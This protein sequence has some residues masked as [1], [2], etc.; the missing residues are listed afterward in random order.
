LKKILNTKILIAS[1]LKNSEK[2]TESRIRIFLRLNSNP[3]G[4]FKVQWVAAISWN[5]LFLGSWSFPQP[6][7]MP[8]ER[9]T[10]QGRAILP[11][12]RIFSSLNKKGLYKIIVKFY[13]N[14]KNIEIP[15]QNYITNAKLWKGINFF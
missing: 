11:A 4:Y 9:N 2:F 12:S 13:Q 5:W 14:V 8:W 6:P 15:H 7:R 3:G 10:P 1:I